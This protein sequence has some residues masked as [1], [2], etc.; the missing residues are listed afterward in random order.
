[1]AGNSRARGTASTTPVLS[2]EESARLRDL[3]LGEIVTLQSEEESATKWARQALAAKNRLTA[4]D[5]KLL[6]EAFE[7][8]LSEFLP[9]VST[10]LA[11][12]DAD[13]TAATAQHKIRGTMGP[14][15][16]TPRASTRACSRWARPAGTATGNTCSS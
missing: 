16:P 13:E 5:A 15:R 9:S 4:Q 10:Q 14:I 7:K 2:A 3:L 6:E 8:K 11:T 1:M 12:Q